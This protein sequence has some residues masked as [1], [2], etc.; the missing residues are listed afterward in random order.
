MKKQLDTAESKAQECKKSLLAAQSEVNALKVKLRGQERDKAISTELDRVRKALDNAESNK[1]ERES[2]IMELERTLRLESKK[3]TIVEEQ[4]RE[5][6]GLQGKLSNIEGERSE[7]AKQLEEALEVISTLHGDSEAELLAARE[8]VNDLKTLVEGMARMYGSL[9]SSTVSKTQLEEEKM[10]F[11]D[12][13]RRLIKTERRL[14]DKEAQVQELV[15]YLRYKG[16]QQDLLARSL[17]DAEEEIAFLRSLHASSSNEPLQQDILLSS[18]EEE[19]QQNAALCESELEY[20]RTLQEFGQ[21]WLDILLRECK[22]ADNVATSLGAALNLVLERTAE[23]NGQLQVTQI[24]SEAARKRARETDEE[25]GLVK[26]EFERQQ[27][28]KERLSEEAHRQ[29][30]QLSKE[31]ADVRRKFEEAKRRG[32]KAEISLR[33]KTAAEKALADDIEG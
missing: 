21:E 26:A 27:G 31:L 14:L 32:E 11:M 18:I 22:A 25:V 7:L 13:Q 2:K 5:L 28:E 30:Q 12:A 29:I 10:R 15:V 4:I 1:R 6:K 23:L 8:E 17:A 33:E 24:E 20:T 9:F 3:R 19:L 16:E